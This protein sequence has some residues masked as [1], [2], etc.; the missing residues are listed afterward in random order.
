MLSKKEIEKFKENYRKEF[1]REMPDDELEV[2]LKGEKSS[3]IQRKGSD[4][5]NNSISVGNK[6]KQIILDAIVI[7]L[8]LSVSI[9]GIWVGWFGMKIPSNQK[10][11]YWFLYW[12]L[13]FASMIIGGLGFILVISKIFIKDDN[14]KNKVNII[15]IIFLA[16]SAALIFISRM[17]I[18]I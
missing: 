15:A 2:F 16:I 13:F 10:H 6:R 9:I 14:I 11:Y 18:S 17:F 5:H 3:T 12:G 4:I 8:I 1:G 7:V